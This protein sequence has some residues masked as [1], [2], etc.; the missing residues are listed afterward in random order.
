[1]HIFFFSANYGPPPHYVFDKL[2]LTNQKTASKISQIGFK[3]DWV[4]KY[5]VLLFGDDDKKIVE[6]LIPLSELASMGFGERQA[7]EAL[8]KFDNDKDSALD[9]LIS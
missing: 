1:M 5:G 3:M 6:H 8:V 7:S 2:S 9:Y 4:I